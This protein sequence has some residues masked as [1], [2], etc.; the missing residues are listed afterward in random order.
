[1]T[2]GAF[3]TGDT[4]RDLMARI[5]VDRQRDGILGTAPVNPAD[6]FAV[7]GALLEKSGAYHHVQPDNDLD[8]DPAR[9]I[10]H[11][12]EVFRQE[13]RRLGRL[14]AALTETSEAVPEEIQTLWSDL[15]ARHGASPLFAILTPGAVCPDWWAVALKL[16]MSAD[17]AMAD[18]VGWLP[19]SEL[20]T[21]WGAAVRAVSTQ[22][23]VD[24]R[25]YLHTI[26]F[27]ANPDIVNVLPKSRTPSVGCTLRSLSQNLALLPSRGVARAYW[28]APA[29][30]PPPD[31]KALNLLIVPYPYRVSAKSFATCSPEV[32][33]EGREWG[34]FDLKQSWL[35]DLRPDDISNWVRGLIAAAHQD[36]ETIHGIV[37]PELA[38]TRA[39]FDRL[40]KELDRIPGFEL[41]IA[42]VSDDGE[43]RN[44]NFVATRLMNKASN[45][46]VGVTRVR[47][48]HHRWRLESAQVGGYALSSALPPPAYWWERLDILSRSL[49]IFVFRKDS[50]L[51]TLICE[52]LARVD[53]CQELVRSIGPNLV[54]ALLMDSAQ[55]KDRWPARYATVLAE[56][57]GC[58]VLTLTSRALLDRA[59]AEGQWGR[60]DAIALWRDDSGRLRSIEAGREAD[61]VLL[62]LAGERRQER[63]MDGRLSTG[64]SVSWRYHG[65]QPIKAEAAEDLRA[66]IRG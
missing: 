40:A 64:M 33:M 52:D 65:Q 39:V 43:G 14:W 18:E 44:G 53:P 42:G 21:P 26:A 9:R 8:A 13:A 61:A 46:P 34:W 7:T 19:S 47:E 27:E 30:K 62:T 20:Q 35:S 24:A 11:V 51:T 45:D 48:K 38:M 55:I 56:D 6:V 10:V 23:L 37:F 17:E 49:D 36:C 22:E 31:P 63:S 12:D 54:V 28:V 57:P 66:R 50:A 59:N 29:S 5:L 60:S 2:F 15:H 32:R 58:S 16:F 1:M 3:G 25:G 41:L 4:V